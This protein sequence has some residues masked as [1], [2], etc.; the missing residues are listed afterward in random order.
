MS[1]SSII[2]A[3][4]VDSNGDSIKIKIKTDPFINGSISDI[5]N[6]MVA[7][8]LATID[9]EDIKSGITPFFLACEH[10]KNDD[11]IKWFIDTNE[12]DLNFK[13]AHGLN[14]IDYL[15]KS[16]VKMPFIANRIEYIIDSQ[17]NKSNANYE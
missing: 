17:K 11:L 9:M 12:T 15:L 14:I 16:K 4:F 8:P 2:N 13:N 7:N 10:N 6:W 3:L 1:I 5:I